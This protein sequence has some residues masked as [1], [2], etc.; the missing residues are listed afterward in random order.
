MIQPSSFRYQVDAATS[1]ATITLDR[2]ARLIEQ[3]R[4]GDWHAVQIEIRHAVVARVVKSPHEE[5]VGR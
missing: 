2:P 1:V 5:G 3:L 4:V